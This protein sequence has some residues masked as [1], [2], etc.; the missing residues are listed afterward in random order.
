MDIRAQL[1][2]LNE[3]AT[4]KLRRRV[5]DYIRKTPAAL[6]RVAAMLAEAGEIRYK[7]LIENAT[8]KEDTWPNIP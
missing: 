5:E 6:L 8:G 4:A 1:N 2:K 7:D 3:E